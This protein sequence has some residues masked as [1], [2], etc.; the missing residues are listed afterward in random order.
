MAKRRRRGGSRKF[1]LPL[2]PIAGLAAGLWQPIEFAMKGDWF[3]A[4]ETLGTAYTGYSIQQNNWEAQRLLRGLVPLM[5]GGI[6]HKFVGGPPLNINK[7]LARAGVPV[8]RI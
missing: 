2:A 4:A 1:T 7:M 5:I 6:V 8:I 3:S